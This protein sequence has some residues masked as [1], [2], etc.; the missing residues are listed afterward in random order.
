MT[1]KVPGRQKEILL[2]VTKYYRTRLYVPNEH[3]SVSTISRSRYKEPT[4]RPG[5]GHFPM[6]PV[7]PVSWQLTP[8]C[9]AMYYP[10]NRKKERSAS[11]CLT[12]EPRGCSGV[13]PFVRKR[14]VS[15]AIGLAIGAGWFLN[16]KDIHTFRSLVKIS[17][18]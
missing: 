16:G 7:S 4:P 10:D 9:L 14:S 15:R 6:S 17:A 12:T 3:P 8:Q 18:Q 13:V 1:R 11:K 5:P 2:S